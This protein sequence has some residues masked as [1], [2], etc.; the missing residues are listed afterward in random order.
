MGPLTGSV[1]WDL[2]GG[3]YGMGIDRPCTDK[4]LVRQFCD[5]L[6]II[7]KIALQISK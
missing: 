2:R 4:C 6:V 5:K 3:G 1:R 7:R